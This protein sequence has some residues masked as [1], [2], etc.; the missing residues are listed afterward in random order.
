MKMKHALAAVMLGWCF[1]TKTTTYT[2][3]PH[4][5]EYGKA[6][7]KSTTQQ[8][9]IG[10]AVQVKS[11]EL[12]ADYFETSEAL[13][14]RNSGGWFISGGKIEWSGESKEND[15]RL[16]RAKSKTSC[17]EITLAEFERIKP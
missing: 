16:T 12:S 1:L 3:D 7:Q 10:E 8:V 2:V 4:R 9:S 11:D 17:E 5:A 13:Y 6:L 14:F 15:Y